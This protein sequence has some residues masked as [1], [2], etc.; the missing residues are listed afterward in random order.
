MRK[1]YT[2]LLASITPCFFLNAYAQKKPIEVEIHAENT[3]GEYP[4]IKGETNLPENMILMITISSPDG[5]IMGQSKTSVHNHL[6]S[7]ERFSYMGAPYNHG[8]YMVNILSPFAPIQDESVQK[9]IGTH[10]EWMRG[11]V[12]ENASVG[13]A[14][15]IVSYNFP[16]HVN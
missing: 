11:S 9:V 10:G 12:V 1:F 13:D 2:I 4:V 15:R 3:G 5:D 8:N 16:F 6:F 14:G 7:S